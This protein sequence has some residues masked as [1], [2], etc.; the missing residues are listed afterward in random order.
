[1]VSHIYRKLV[2]TT[3]ILSGLGLQYGA[4]AQTQPRTFED[5]RT[6]ANDARHQEVL[7]SPEI[8]QFLKD[9]GVQPAANGKVHLVRIKNVKASVMA[10]WLDPA[11]NTEPNEFVYSNRSETRN[12]PQLPNS[13][14]IRRPLGENYNLPEGVSLTAINSRNVLYILA[15]DEAMQQVQKNIDLLDKP[16]K[17]IEIETQYIQVSPKEM[18][19][20]KIP[21]AGEANRPNIKTSGPFTLGFPQTDIKAKIAEL[22]KENKA[23]VFTAPRV[24]AINTLTAEIRTT[25]TM[26]AVVNIK[27][28]TLIFKTDNST[29]SD[30]T[31]APF[32]ISVSVGFAARPTIN[33]DKTISLLLSPSRT[34][35]LQQ[36]N[37]AQEPKSLIL[38]NLDNTQSIENLEDGDTIAL[39]GGDT[40]LIAPVNEKLI[41]TKPENLLILVTPRIIR[42]ASDED[43]E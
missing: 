31:T 32:N 16:L 24:T 15:A 37:K 42:R 14:S 5:F 10:W 2:A 29:K 28:S 35:E 27:D 9:S 6:L 4:Q 1:M 7:G 26:P 34:L 39:I 36:T 13:Y 20:L 8:V 22:L 11:H 3:V 40:R 19:R 17:Q 38:G 18:K 23:R 41:G 33:K 25:T 12:F 43:N 21:T 30:T